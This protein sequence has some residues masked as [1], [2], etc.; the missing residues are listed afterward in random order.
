MEE[1]DVLLRV[2]NSFYLGNFKAVLDT[3]T[4]VVNSGVKLSPKVDEQVGSLVQRM[5]VVYLRKN[6]KVISVHLVRPGTPKVFR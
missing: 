5:I 1:S 6:A 3:W 2:K 4:E